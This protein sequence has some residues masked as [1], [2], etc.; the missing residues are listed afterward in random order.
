MKF[1]WDGHIGP[2]SIVGAAGI[3]IQAGVVVWAISA[4]KT[5]VDNHFV[6]VDT[7]FAE[8]TQ[9]VEKIAKGSNDRFT[10]V[11]AALAVAQ[12]NQ[13]A[14]AERAGKI[15]TA[16]GYVTTQM[17]QLVSRLDGKP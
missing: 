14:L 5:N 8:Q 17:Q 12:N 6:Q 3:L 13:A 9:H 1:E 15:E 10:E 7:K 11:H 2:A 4:F 16:I